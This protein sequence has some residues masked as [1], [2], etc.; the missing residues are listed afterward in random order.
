MPIISKDKMQERQTID[1][2]AKHLILCEGK[3]DQGFLEQFMCSSAFSEHEMDDVQVLR[4]KGKDNLRNEMKA[5]CV[6]PGFSHICSLLVIRDADNNIESARDSVKDAFRERLLPVP[7]AE[8]IW[9]SNERIKTGFLLMPSC[10][11]HSQN[12]A[13][14]DLCW[15]IMTEKQGK[16]IHEEVETFLQTLEE[17]EIRKYSHKNKALLHT[18]FSATDKL[19]AAS[20]GR[21]AEMGAF[22]WSSPEL[23]PLHDFLVE[24]VSNTTQDVDETLE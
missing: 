7:D 8:Y 21:A 17:S 14:E 9:A 15:K 11:S 10:S 23:K 4:Y 1:D 12:G 5:F 19:I 18:Y 2:A 20:I 3:D 13:L 6:A 16:S 24:M 22:D